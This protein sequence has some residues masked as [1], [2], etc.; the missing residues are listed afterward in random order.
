[1]LRSKG[2]FASGLE[3]VWRLWSPWRGAALFIN[4]CRIGQ[5][6]LSVNSEGAVPLIQN[7]GPSILHINDSKKR[8]KQFARKFRAFIKKAPME[9]PYDSASASC[10]PLHLKL[11]VHT[12]A[13]ESFR[14]FRRKSG[15]A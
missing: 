1:V 6:G 2:K 12:S 14:V 7:A 5:V 13:E 15:E 3:A 9:S 8:F 11:K 4:G 10:T